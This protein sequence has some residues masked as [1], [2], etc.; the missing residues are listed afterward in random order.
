MYP[1]TRDSK[2]VSTFKDNSFTR[3][4]FSK[5]YKNWL[6]DSYYAH[7]AKKSRRVIKVKG[8][9]CALVETYSGQRTTMSPCFK[10]LGIKFN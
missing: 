8:W 3:W 4:L 2:R 10:L 6:A 1:D 5:V 7:G 9:R